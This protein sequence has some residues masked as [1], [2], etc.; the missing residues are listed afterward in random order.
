MTVAEGHGSDDGFFR[1]PLLLHSLSELREVIFPCLDLSGART[2]VEVG[3]EDGT[4]TRELLAWAQKSQGAVYCVDPQPSEKLVQLCAQSDAAELISDR[5][6]EAL[7]TLDRADAYVLDGDHNYYTVKSE[8]EAIERK[9]RNGDGMPLVFLHDVGWPCG[10]RDQYYSPESLPSE[11]VHPHTYDRGVTPESRGVIEG[12]FR[13]AGEFAFAVQEGGEANGV[14]TAVEDFLEGHADLALAKVPCVFGLGVIYRMS[15]PEGRAAGEL[16]RPY[17]GNP[18]LERLERNRM[19]LFLRV[20]ETQ[21][22]LRSIAAQLESAALQVR[23]VATENRALWA[24]NA[25]LESR[26]SVLE[27][28]LRS[29]LHSSAFVVAER[30]S[31]LRRVTPERPGLSRQRL[32]AA[33]EGPDSSP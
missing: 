27:V 17:D 20:L 22:D 8:L 2:I 1:A 31:S 32:R 5:S 23:D 21:D 33:L 9:S 24:R 3:G 26:V 28:E 16:L 7:D 30:L 19:A 11:A 6:P 25:E 15:S 12:G 13:G 4:F 10:R 29:V 14:L 18:L